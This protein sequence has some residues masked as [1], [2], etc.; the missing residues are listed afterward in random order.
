MVCDIFQRECVNEG[1]VNI[2]MA[3]KVVRLADQW[4]VESRHGKYGDE[5]EKKCYKP[6]TSH[7]TGAKVRL[8]QEIIGIFILINT[9][10]AEPFRPFNE[11]FHSFV[12]KFGERTDGLL[13]CLFCCEFGF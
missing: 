4:N 12:T 11:S 5:Y 9:N 3:D 13:Q 2:M 8:F 10:L 6:L 7:K 1:G